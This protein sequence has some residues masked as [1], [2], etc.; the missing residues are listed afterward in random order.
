MKKRPIAFKSPKFSH[1]ENNHTIGVQEFTKIMHALC[2]W[3]FYLEVEDCV[4]SI[5]HNPFIYLKSQQI[6]SRHQ[7][8]WSEDFKKYKWEYRLGH[9]DIANP[10]SHIILGGNAYVDVL[11][12][13]S[14]GCKD[15][16][17]RALL[18]MSCPMVNFGET[19]VNKS[20][21]API[22]LAN[23]VC[24][25]HKCINEQLV[26]KEQFFFKPSL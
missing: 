10:L 7:A 19:V 1:A 21:G 9:I 23:E 6:L 26:A 24:S 4:V 14:L 18:A 8:W 17:L 22:A 13:N 12:H 25:G 20:K 15:V 11:S 2:T 3:H 5:E 16:R